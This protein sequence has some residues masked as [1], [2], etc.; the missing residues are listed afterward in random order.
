M[1]VHL[2][3]VHPLVSVFTLRKVVRSITRDCVVCKRHKGKPSFQLQGQLPQ[4]LITP[5]SVFERVG[6]D[7]A[8]PINIKYGFVRRPTIVKA[9]VCLFVSLTVKAVHL[10]LVSDL[11]TEAFIAAL[12]RFTARR[13][14]PMLIW[15]DIG[16]NFVGANRELKHLIDFMKNQTTQRGISEFCASKGIEWR[17]FPERTPH[18]GGLWEAAVKSMK[19][20]LRHIMCDVRLTFE[21]TSTVLCQI[22]ACLNSR[23]LIPLN[24]INSDI[25]DVLT[26]GHF[27]IGHSLIALPDS[28]VNSE[29]QMC[30]LRH[31]HL[32]QNL[33]N[34]FWKRWSTEYVTALNKFSKWTRPSRN[35]SIGDIVILRDETLFPTKWPLAKVVDVH[36]GRDNFVRVVT[37]KTTKGIYKRPITKVVVLLPAESD[38]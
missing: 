24:H 29:L 25:A 30:L 21:E 1:L 28:S 32:C 9:Y 34:H 20:H 12:R 14:Y 37:V 16:T 7:Y 2:Y 5:G 8:G 38:D 35:V 4:E 33:V 3:C 23:P 11:T 19:T 26:P 6:V 31:W 17:F 36:P 27:L 13:G 18:F 10:E 22:E 15:S